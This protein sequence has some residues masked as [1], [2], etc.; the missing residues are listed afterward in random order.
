MKSRK[1]PTP[2]PWQRSRYIDN[3]ARMSKEYV[4]KR[5]AEEAQIIRG[6]GVVGTSAC[7]IVARVEWC[8]NPADFTLMIAA[9][10]LLAALRA[11]LEDADCDHSAYAI[12]RA[13]AAIRK[14]GG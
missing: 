1:T 11:V 8:P 4:A 13:R 2:G 14:A 10:E 3:G 5:E 6:P 9:P 12:E 7:N